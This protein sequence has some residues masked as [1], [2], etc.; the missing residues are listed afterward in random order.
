MWFTLLIPFPPSRRNLVGQA[1]PESWYT[2]TVHPP[3]HVWYRWWQVK[4]TEV[5]SSLTFINYCEFKRPS[6]SSNFSFVECVIG[7][8]WL[9][10]GGVHLFKHTW[11]ISK[12]KQRQ[13]ER[14]LINYYLWQNGHF[15]IVNL[16]Q[17]YKLCSKSM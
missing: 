11:T 14:K 10:K 5:L 4:M 6:R 17:L 15:L 3:G 16:S 12:C 13:D 7:E 9:Y 8:F 2:K 1:K